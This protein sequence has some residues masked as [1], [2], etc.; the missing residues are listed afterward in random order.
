MFNTAKSDVEA[1]AD[2]AGRLGDWLLR[3]V[4]VASVLTQL[5]ALPVTFLAAWLL[6]AKVESLVG[7]IP[8]PYRKIVFLIAIKIG[9]LHRRPHEVARGTRCP[10]HG[11]SLLPIRI[12]S[13]PA[14]GPAGRK[15]HTMP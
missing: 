3:E 1:A 8:P 7:R 6:H 9:R 14:Y 11:P 5:A 2:L 12:A 13:L 4:L 15:D 10:S